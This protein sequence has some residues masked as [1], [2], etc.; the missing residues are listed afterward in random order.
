[1]SGRASAWLRSWPGMIT[2][3]AVVV[4]GTVLALSLTNNPLSPAGTQDTAARAAAGE[5]VSPLALESPKLSPELLERQAALDKAKA[6]GQAVVV[7]GATSQF[8]LV[9]AQPDGTSFFC[10][11]NC[12]SGTD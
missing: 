10:G 6:T 12:G 11:V 5:S 2:V 9:K 7:D 1:M 8:G 4:C 3:I